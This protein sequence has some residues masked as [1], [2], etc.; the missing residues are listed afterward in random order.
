MLPQC[1]PPNF[2]SIRLTI[3]EQLTTEDFQDGHYGGLHGCPNKMILAILHLNVTSMPP[4][5]FWLTPTYHL[6]AD[7]VSRFSRWPLCWQSWISEQNTFSD[8]K[9]L[10]CFNA[11]YQVSAPSNIRLSR[12]CHCKNF[13][14]PTMAAIL[15]I[16]TD[17]FTNSESPGLPSASHQISAKS[18]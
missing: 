18:D 2:G 11:F 8:F 14:M 10:C 16:K 3:Q 1:L 7:V 15:D 12:R 17:S 9:K 5:N 4:T 13:K 6:G